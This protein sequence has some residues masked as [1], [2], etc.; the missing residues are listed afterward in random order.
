[1][2]KRVARPL[3][4]SWSRGIEQER[5][6]ERDRRAAR[7][8]RSPSRGLP[9]GH[10][11]RR[12]YGPIARGT[13]RA[14]ARASRDGAEASS[15]SSATSARRP[16]ARWFA[17]GS[18]RGS[19]AS[20]RSRSARPPR[21]SSASPRRR[22]GARSTSSATR[23]AGS[24][25]RTPRSTSMRG[26]CVRRVVTLGTPHRGTALALSGARFLGRVA[27]SLA[28]M[29]PGCALPRRSRPRGAPRRRLAGVGRGARGSRRARAVRAAPAPR[30]TPQPVACRTPTTGVSSTT[31]RRRPSSS[32][33]CVARRLLLLCR[34]DATAAPE[35][36][37]RWSRSA[38]PCR[39]KNTDRTSWSV[40]P[41]APRRRA[42]PSR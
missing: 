12:A 35:E 17:S 36:D 8:V 31:R 1:M 7:D 14:P 26:A 37:P 23:W 9:G 15:R 24:S 3:P 34:R 20:S 4:L 41:A 22:A 2:P 40:S 18:A 6:H 32:A 16:G 38:T 25:R 42:S 5:R 13:D 27:A 30:P 33:S 39:V 21:A 11:A 29:V 19:T 10:R 28:Q